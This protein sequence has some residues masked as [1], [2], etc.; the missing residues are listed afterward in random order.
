MKYEH[1]YGYV[2][3]DKPILFVIQSCKFKPVENNLYEIRDDFNGITDNDLENLNQYCY[4]I[5]LK[6]L[7]KNFNMYYYTGEVQR[8]YSVLP[9]K[10]GVNESL[11][12]DCEPVLKEDVS[13]A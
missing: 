2:R 4:D 3:C 7:D 10:V 12:K 8:L 5:R 13:N 9:W 11:L 1:F 6:L